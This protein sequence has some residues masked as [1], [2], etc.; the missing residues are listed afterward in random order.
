M[1]MLPQN[2]PDIREF[3]QASLRVGLMPDG[4]NPKCN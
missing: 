2:A 3:M 1:G 4:R